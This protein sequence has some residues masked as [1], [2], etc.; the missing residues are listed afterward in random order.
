MLD[1]HALTAAGADVEI[2]DRP[3]DSLAQDEAGTGR[4]AEGPSR[5]L[6]ACLFRTSGGRGPGGEEHERGERTQGGSAPPFCPDRRVGREGA[7]CA[8]KIIAA[9]MPM[10]ISVQKGAASIGPSRATSKLASM[11]IEAT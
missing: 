8:R 6:R 2:L 4:V 11:M 3:V 9:P 5:R 10:P 7:A 1:P